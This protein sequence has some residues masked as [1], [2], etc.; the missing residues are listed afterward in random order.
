[1]EI[2]MEADCLTATLPEWALTADAGPGSLAG[3]PDPDDVAADGGWAPDDRR[4]MGGRAR[5][6]RSQAGGG[7]RR[8]P[9]WVV[10]WMR[11]QAGSEA[12]G[13]VGWKAA[14]QGR[15]AGL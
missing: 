6:A 11:R 1:M 13:S 2:R 15:I 12:A 9:S 14:R 10:T 3:W 4:R 8:A 7:G 5:R